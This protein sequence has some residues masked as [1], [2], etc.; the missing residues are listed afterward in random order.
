MPLLAEMPAVLSKSPD[1]EYVAVVGVIE[2]E[3]AIEASN[4]FLTSVQ[5]HKQN[6]R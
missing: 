3:G 5:E 6:M 2:Q 1:G 4:V